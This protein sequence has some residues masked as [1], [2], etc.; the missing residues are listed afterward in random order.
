MNAIISIK[1]REIREDNQIK[2]KNT[3]KNSEI[4]APTAETSKRNAASGLRKH[5]LSI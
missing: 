3:S 5:E 2:P 4:R 1:V